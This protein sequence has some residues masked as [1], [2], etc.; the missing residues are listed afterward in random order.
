[1]KKLHS[2]DTIAETE[3]GH[4]LRDSKGMNFL[5]NQL[6]VRFDFRPSYAAFNPFLAGQAWG[7]S[8]TYSIHC[9]GRSVFGGFL[10]VLG[11]QAKE[12]GATL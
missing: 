8:S 12:G 10:V 5:H 3:D 1:M 9:L 6:L 2:T 7:T 4:L 11:R